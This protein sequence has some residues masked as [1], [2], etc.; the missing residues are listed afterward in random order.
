MGYEDHP[1]GC[2][3]PATWTLPGVS[4]LAWMTASTRAR[5]QVPY[6][7]THVAYGLQALR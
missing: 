1:A 7:L 6:K 3:A 5:C 4:E 2:A